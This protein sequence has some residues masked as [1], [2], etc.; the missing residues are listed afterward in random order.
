MSPVEGREPFNDS[1]AFGVVNLRR[2]VVY[3]PQE[4][5]RLGAS[6]TLSAALLPEFAIPVSSL[7]EV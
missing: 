2:V 6:E 5:R 4:S 3:T 7:F 1:A